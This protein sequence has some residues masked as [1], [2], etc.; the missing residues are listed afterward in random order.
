MVT[1]AALPATVI[2]DHD[3]RAARGGDLSMDELTPAAASLTGTPIS[4]V[5]VPLFEPAA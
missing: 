2:R 1:D 5:R 4:I 3:A